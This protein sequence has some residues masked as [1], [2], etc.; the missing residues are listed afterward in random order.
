MTSVIRGEEDVVAEVVLLT[1]QP[2][3]VLLSYLHLRRLVLLCVLEDSLLHVSVLLPHAS[4]VS[5][6]IDINRVVP[7]AG[8]DLNHEGAGVVGAAASDDVHLTNTVPRRVEVKIASRLAQFT[9]KINRCLLVERALVTK[10]ICV[11]V[12]FTAVSDC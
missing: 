1:D 4:A 10:L 3:H 7:A 8:F 2:H 5:T 11:E 12:K 9:S 6:Q